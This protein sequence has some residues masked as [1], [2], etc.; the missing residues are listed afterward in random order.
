MGRVGVDLYAEQEGARL[1]D[2]TSF[3]KYIGGSAANVCAGAS[4]LGLRTGMLD[5]VGDEQMGRFVR[6]AMAKEGIDVSRLRRA[7]DRLTTLVTL[8]VRET[9]DF[10]RIFF[11]ENAADLAVAEQDIDVDWIASSAALLVGGTLLA[12]PGS[13]AAARKAIGAA[14]R[15][16]AKVILDV[17]YRPVLWG[18]AGH[19]A[20]AEM[21]VPSQNVSDAIQSALGDCDL[22]VGTDHEIRIAGGSAQTHEALKSIR[23]STDA[24]IVLKVG[25]LGCL[26]DPGEIPPNHHDGIRGQGVRVEVF[27]SVGAGDA[28]MSS[29]LRGWLTEAPIERCAR[30]ANACGALV[31]SRHGCSPAMPSW[32]ELCN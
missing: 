24:L 15:A 20:G 14:R 17:D 2:V 10:P 4:R 7:P 16:G 1:E 6:E 19:Q 12:R 32:E 25:A 28:F 18:L 21:F 31:V 9:E 29:F 13:A 22:V 3:R 23:A 8:G 11:A 30:L 26:M 27:N 5:R